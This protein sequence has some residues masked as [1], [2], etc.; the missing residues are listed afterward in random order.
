MAKGRPLQQIDLLRA[1]VQLRRAAEGYRQPGA[2]QSMQTLVG[3][4]LNDGFDPEDTAPNGLPYYIDIAIR[5]GRTTQ[6]V[7]GCFRSPDR[8]GV[9]S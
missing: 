4:A 8:Y 7:Y 2:R 5:T 3:K 1:E 6:D 9:E